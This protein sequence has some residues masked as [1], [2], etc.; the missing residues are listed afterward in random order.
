MPKTLEMLAQKGQFHLSSEL[1]AKLASRGFTDIISR[2]ANG[3]R[4]LLNYQ[5]VNSFWSVIYSLEFFSML[6]ETVLSTSEITQIYNLNRLVLGIILLL[7]PGI[8]HWQIVLTWLMNKYFVIIP[9]MKKSQNSCP[10]VL[11]FHSKHM[12]Q[13]MVLM[14]I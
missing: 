11:S 3:E 8:L 9:L 14:S 7:V 13:V 10:E 6:L 4:E 5:T 1:Q 2:S 12:L